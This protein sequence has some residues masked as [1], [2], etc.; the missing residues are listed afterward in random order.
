MDEEK[1]LQLDEDQQITEWI[2]GGITKD[3]IEFSD[4]FGKDLCA[5]YKENGRDKV[6]KAAVTTSQIRNFFSEVKRIQRESITSDNI[7]RFLLL[8]PKLAY[9]MARAIQKNHDS[10]MK[11]FKEVMEVAHRAVD[12]SSEIELELRFQRFVDF[13]EAILAYHKSYGGGAVSK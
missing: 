12:P 13:F 8:R 4:R 11:I 6:G 3:T 9:A 10:R 7:S 2:Q 1:Y 5:L